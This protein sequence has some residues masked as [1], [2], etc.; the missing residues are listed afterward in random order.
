MIQV[1]SLEEGAQLCHNPTQDMH[2][3]GKKMRGMLR[4]AILRY[5]SKASDGGN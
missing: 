2:M 5:L 4:T 3:L 1:L